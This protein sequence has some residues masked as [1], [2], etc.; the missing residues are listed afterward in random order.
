MV[1]VLIM[2]TYWVVLASKPTLPEPE[3]R[4]STTTPGSTP[5]FDAI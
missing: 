3:R 2:S 1:P 4:R 5:E